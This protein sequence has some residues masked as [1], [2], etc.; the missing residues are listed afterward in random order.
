MA[1]SGSNLK[2]RTREKCSHRWASWSP[3]LG[4]VVAL[5]VATG[6]AA[7]T[8]RFPTDV[9]SAIQ[10][11][12]MRR[13]ETE[14]LQVY[15]PEGRASE[16]RQMAARLETCLADLE[17]RLPVPTDW[18][19]V[20]VVMPELE[21]NN[22]YVAFGP[23]NDPHIL[24]PT[25]F[26]TP[27]LQES[28]LTPSPSAVGCHEMVHY[29][30][31]IQV[32]GA[33][34]T[35]NRLLGPS[36]NPQQ[37]FDLWFFEG[38]ATYY[39]G[40]L[41]EGV[42]RHGSPLWDTL[43]A[44]GLSDASFQAGQLSEWDRAIPVGGHYLF[45][46]YFVA[47]L[48][49][50]Y[51]EEKLWQLVDRQGR[52]TFFP[53]GMNRRFRQ[54]YGRTMEELIDDFR[55]HLSESYERRSRPEA[56]QRWDWLGRRALFEVGPQDQ[57]ATFSQD[58]DQVPTLR[59]E[60]A[61]GEELVSTRL[62]D[63]RPLRRIRG[64][65]AIDGLRFSPDGQHLVMVINHRGRSTPRTDVLS[66]E[67]ASGRWQ[68]LLADS[69]AV[70]IDTSPDGESL[71]LA[72]IEGQSVILE[73]VYPEG[74][75]DARQR[76][77]ALP[78][79]SYV[80]S[81]RVSPSGQKVA[82]GLMEDE[83]WSVAIADVE[84]GQWQYQWQ[85][86]QGD[87]PV[88]SPY[89]I[90]DERLMVAAD[91]G[92]RGV[93]IYELSTVDG[94][95][96]QR[97]QAPYMATSPQMRGDELW[98]L[99]RE[100]WGWSLDRW[101][102]DEDVGGDEATGEAPLSAVEPPEVSGY[103]PAPAASVPVL[104][105]EPYSQLDGLFRPR[106]RLPQLM[107]YEGGEEVE[108]GFAASGRDEL[109]IHN[110]AV[111][112]WWDFR[113]DE[114]SA[115][116]GYVWTRLA[117]WMVSLQALDS[118]TRLRVIDGTEEG[119]LLEQRDRLARL[120]IQ[121]TFYDTT[122][123]TEAMAAEFQRSA[124]PDRRGIDNRLSGAAVGL[125]HGASRTSP[126]GGRQQGWFAATQAGAYPRWLGS[127]FEL[128]QLR[129]QLDWT[130]SPPLSTRHQ[131]QLGLRG[132]RLGGVPD[133]RPLMR[134]GGFTNLESIAASEEPREQ[135]L[136]HHLVPR[137]FRFS[138]ALRG[139]EDLGLATNQVAIADLQYRFPFIIDRGDPATFR[140]FPAVFVR[141]IDLELFATAATRFDDDV[142]AAAGASL[143]LSL[144]FW[145][146]PLRLRYQIAQ[147]LVD[148]EHLV[149]TLSSVIGGTW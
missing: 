36:I 34:S 28:G 80:S 112:L 11:E 73:R 38:L 61:Q 33:Y 65:G 58:V 67:I 108:L 19:L 55:V 117:P 9:H 146:A 140:Y 100:G 54:I 106:L 125:E 5:W 81:L 40:Q 93:Q 18:G 143:D 99:N 122:L 23:G 59:V 56:Q 1:L 111:D 47:Y 83:R 39:E 44:A 46:S 102:D 109:G 57:L 98:A 12:D 75:A 17:E 96:V 141:Q 145:R 113:R 130:R 26:T 87:R 74:G 64:L 37:G 142:H 70:A 116:V 14:R 132:H 134:V 45:G 3:W 32:H 35:I 10:D 41:V 51:G 76:L 7:A 30:H 60:D 138:E 77:W 50:T 124:S 25:S 20:P 69:Q 24:V 2:T 129:A 86:G 114:P 8:P 79:G 92:Q 110:W 105:D 68:T 115:S 13:M 52:S 84:S 43:M 104:R 118:R 48:V 133:D 16:A 121:R 72:R 147:R 148:D 95:I 22:A 119:Q 103:D 31:L 63:I 139:Y 42:G 29:V 101:V 127:D 144:I 6:C 94:D 53:F 62:P 85:G 66:L 128:T 78:E 88:Y 89:W 71:I 90:D 126:Y 131:L 120:Q 136:A 97:S 49:D 135:P 82:L 4:L 91:D 123:W 21:F 149:H 15:Y 137:S 107:I 27:L